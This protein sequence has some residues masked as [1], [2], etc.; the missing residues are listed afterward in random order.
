MLFGS[1]ADTAVSLDISNWDIPPQQQSFNEHF[2]YTDWAFLW[3]YLQTTPSCTLCLVIEF[4][5]TVYSLVWQQYLTGLSIGSW[6]YLHLSIYSV[7][8]IN[9]SKVTKV[10]RRRNNVKRCRKTSRVKIWSYTDI[11]LH[12]YN[13]TLDPSTSGVLR[14]FPNG[15]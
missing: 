1:V 7:M 4:R 15:I 9:V 10:H 8:H 12:M 13:V 5:L 3:V 14:T 2:L 6:N 11:G